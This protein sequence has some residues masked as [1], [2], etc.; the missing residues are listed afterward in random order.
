MSD[1][2]IHFVN[3]F[4][5]NPV[6]NETENKTFWPRYKTFAPTMLVFTGNDTFDYKEDTYRQEQIAFINELNVG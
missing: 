5:P 6:G 4:D 3:N 1:L 2:F